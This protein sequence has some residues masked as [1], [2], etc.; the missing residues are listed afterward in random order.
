MVITID[1]Y[2]FQKSIEITSYAYSHGRVS[3]AIIRPLKSV[4]SND[5]ALESIDYNNYSLEFVQDCDGIWRPY[6]KT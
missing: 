2:G 5:Y 1:L 3:C 4:I 6:G